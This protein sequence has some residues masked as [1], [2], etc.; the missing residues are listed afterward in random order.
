VALRLVIPEDRRC[1]AQLLH[2]VD[3][4]RR[5]RSMSAPG[6]EHRRR[7]RV[8]WW[9]TVAAAVLAVLAV[10]GIVRTAI[11]DVAEHET[12]GSFNVLP[13]PLPPGPPGSI[14][15]SERLLGAPDGAV[16]WRVLYHSTDLEG[17]DIGVSGVVVAPSRWAPSGGWPVV[18]W[19]HPTTG[20]YGRCAPSEALDPF[21][22]MAGLHELLAAGYVVA[23]T[24]YSGMGAS[25]PPSYLIGS[26][27][28]RNVL[29]AARAARA[30]PDAHAGEQLALWGHS[31]GGQAALFA[32]Q[33]APTYAPDLR[34]R[35][36]AVA[37]P[38]ADLGLLLNDHRGDVSGVT[39]GSYAFD[40][41]ARVYGP[42]DPRVDLA[43]LLTP[44]GAAVV[45][46]IAPRCLLTDVG[47]LHTIAQP[48]VGHFF[49]VD[50]AT[51][52]PWRSILSQN[53]P[54]S[55]PVRVPVLVT[56][57]LA[58]ELVLPSATTALVTSLCRAGEHVTYREYPGIDHGLAG[59]RTVPLLLPWLSE[60]LAGSTPTS[61]CSST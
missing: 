7:P 53:T 3:S 8:R 22:L 52:E 44:A 5:A 60:V 40:A 17:R 1:E 61:S 47:A 15:R 55:V 45:P 13:S 32:A 35:A 20:A 34:L 27:E 57:G 6:A 11:S 21:A 31:Q 25:G 38:A 46:Q 24:D 59:Y 23:A 51:T 42:S 29:D 28:G 2:D 18:S 10:T 16:A 58:D 48:A 49:A 26:T 41:I 50:P 39:I 54:G 12:L 43:T 9:I 56:Q 30:L 33:L 14:I 19:A 4:D 37:A 36:V